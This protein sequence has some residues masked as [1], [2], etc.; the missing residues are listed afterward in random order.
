MKHL[1]FKY[2]FLFAFLFTSSLSAFA[3]QTAT[4]PVAIW[5][6]SQI[7][8]FSLI[9]V[10][11]GGDG[12]GGSVMCAADATDTFGSTVMSSAATAAVQGTEVTLTCS[13]LGQAQQLQMTGGND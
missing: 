8:G 13:D 6:V 1:V 7:P 11:G 5:S 2:V 10:G 12:G 9:S 3:A 4:G